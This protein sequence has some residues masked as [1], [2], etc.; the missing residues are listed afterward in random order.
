MAGAGVVIMPTHVGDAEPRVERAL[1]DAPLIIYPVWLVAHG[2][3]RTSRKVP[4]V[5]DFLAEALG[6]LG[7]TG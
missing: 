2:E 7:Q 6:G 1:P 4:L 3:L 5:S